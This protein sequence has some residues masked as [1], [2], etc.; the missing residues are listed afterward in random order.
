MEMLPIL[1]DAHGDDAHKDI[2]RDPE[3]PRNYHKQQDLFVAFVEKL[4][5]ELYKALQFTV[6]VYGT[7]YQEILSNSSKFLILLRRVLKF[8]EKTKQSQPLGTL[9]LR[10]IEQLHYKPDALNSAIYQAINHSVPEEEKE[11][12]IWPEDS[13]TFMQELVRW[14]HALGNTNN[15][16]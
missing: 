13:K 12:W 9:A 10:L 15:I 16:R 2:D 8:F 4:D 1:I 5:D 14:V 6:D 11:D 3:D 7:D